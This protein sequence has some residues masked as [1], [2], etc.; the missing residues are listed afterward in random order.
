MEEFD[1]FE[2]EFL[3]KSG[4]GVQCNTRFTVWLPRDVLEVLREHA[5]RKGIRVGTYIRMLLV[6]HAEELRSAP[7]IVE[8]EMG[9]L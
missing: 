7:E 2:R 9:G 4:R 8:A 1:E 3:A 6:K 5:R